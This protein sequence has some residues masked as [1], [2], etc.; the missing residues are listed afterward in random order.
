MSRFKPT[1]SRLVA[2]VVA[3]A[4]VG[5]GAGGLSYAASSNSS[6]VITACENVRTGALRLETRKLPCVTNGSTARR[7]REVTW[8]E[9]G[10][11]GAAGAAGAPG[12]PGGSGPAGATGPSGATGAAGD[13]GETGATGPPGPVGPAG[14]TGATGARGEAGADGA[15]GTAGLDGAV[16]P[17]GPT[18][19][20]GPTG[21]PGATGATGATGPAGPQG[22]PGNLSTSTVSLYADQ[23]TYEG[24][25]WYEGMASAWVG[26]W[27]VIAHCV[28]YVQTDVDHQDYVSAWW[29]G[30]DRGT[31][32]QIVTSPFRDSAEANAERPTAY[33]AQGRDTRTMQ[34]MWS[35]GSDPLT[36]VVSRYRT[37][38][39][40][41]LT[42]TVSA[43][44]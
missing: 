13:R 40:C 37:A 34:A 16:G 29:V 7:E 9:A 1:R 30:P 11:A 3:T 18:G 35:D 23:A 26:G 15:A 25:D 20:A 41:Y 21:A 14:P 38:D 36:V 43:N 2:A 19:A 33:L 22:A 28:G 44:P 12:A 42:M 39:K 27:R 31:R 8:N 17:V 24:S 10:V 4:G 6:D 5:L 32:S